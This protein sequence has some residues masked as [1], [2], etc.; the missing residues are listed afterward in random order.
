MV[1]MEKTVPPVAGLKQWQHVC[2]LLCKLVWLIQCEL[3]YLLA[4]Y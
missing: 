1:G 4:V 3:M 2:C